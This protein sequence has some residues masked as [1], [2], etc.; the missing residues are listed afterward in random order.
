MVHVYDLYKCTILEK[1]KFEVLEYMFFRLRFVNFS[2]A[3]LSCTSDLLEGSICIFLKN[4]N[5]FGNA[6]L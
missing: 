3:M 4:K 1:K 5:Y 2:I 6:C